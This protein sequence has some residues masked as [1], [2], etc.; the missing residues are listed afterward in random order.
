M[1]LIE[2]LI[3]RV[4]ARVNVNLREFSFDAGP[5][6]KD[7]VPLKQ[8]LRFN[9]FYGVT[10]HHPLHVNFKNSSLAGSYFLGKCFT[11]NVVLYKTDVRGDELKR[12]G[13]IFIFQG[14]EVPVEK[15]E[16]IHIKDSYL[17]KAL[18]HNYSHDPEAPEEF[19]IRNTLASFYSNIHGAL[20]EGCYIAP[21]ATLDL[22]SLHGCKVGTFA[23]VQSISDL[24]HE[25]IPDGTI[26]MNGETFE[27]KYTYDKEVLDR[28]I[29]N[30]PGGKPEGVL[31]EFMEDRKGDYSDIYSSAVST[32]PV[33]VSSKSALNRYAYV[34]G[35]THIH[36]NVLVSQ[37]A[38]LK[39]A[40]MGPG[41][42]AQEHSY[43]ID[44][45]L[46]KNDITAHGAKLINAHL[47]ERVFVGFNSFI[48]GKADMPVTIGA[49]SMV[50]PH[51]IIDVEEPLV[52][53]ERHAVWGYIR[54]S[55]DL[56]T[57]SISLDDLSKVTGKVTLGNLE[58][59]GSGY[60]LVHGF[61][62]RID[63][64]LAANGAF[65]G[66][67]NKVRGHAQAGHMISYNTLQPYL[68]GKMKGMFPTIDIQ[69]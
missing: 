62:D 27:F 21:F 19:L 2:K 10:S 46:E 14:V 12:K 20:V 69:P 59:S 25:E 36:E 63:H 31:W 4:I 26:W 8:M 15:D 68:S 45:H 11:D 24:Y 22:T 41:T 37:R 16:E 23:F 40:W 61:E 9:A 5:Y 56:K 34:A 64:I 33:T 42:N 47:A 35:D 38:Y 49:G 13:D 28:Y 44:S 66:D 57:H 60:D 65:F 67:V 32:T 29:K 6:A 39:N 18:I 52:I 17:I 50:M 43:V 54:N 48:N 7:V 51:T 3:D 53:P 55:E 1:K 58:F 30:I